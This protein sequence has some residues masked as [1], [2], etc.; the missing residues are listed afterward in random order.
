MPSEWETAPTLFCVTVPQHKTKDDS[1]EYD[2][3]AGSEPRHIG[4]E[5]QAAFD[6]KQR[7]LQWYQFLFT[8]GDN[9]PNGK[10]RYDNFKYEIHVNAYPWYYFRCEIFALIILLNRDYLLFFVNFERMDFDINA[11]SSRLEKMYVA[12]AKNKQNTVALTIREIVA[13]T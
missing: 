12:A 10:D 2:H 1:V 13:E 11:L 3:S 6:A 5:Q 7:N 8:S 9:N 4:I